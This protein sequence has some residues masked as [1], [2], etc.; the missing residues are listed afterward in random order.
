MGAAESTDAV[1]EA[2][3]EKD[4]IPIHRRTKGLYVAEVGVFASKLRQRSQKRLSKLSQNREDPAA[5]GVEEAGVWTAGEW[6]ESLMLHTIIRT[7]S[8]CQRQ[9]NSTSTSRTSVR[10]RCTSPERCL[11]CG[12]RYGTFDTVLGVYCMNSAGQVATTRATRASPPPG[13]S[14]MAHSLA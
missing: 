7:H 6:L 2:E 12:M 3:D 9:L 10:T 11:V 14:G 4:E 13:A 5:K 1:K 8:T